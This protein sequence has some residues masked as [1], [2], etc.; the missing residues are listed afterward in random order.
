MSGH[1]TSIDEFLIT[2]YPVMF[3]SFHIGYTDLDDMFM[4]T[5]CRS[6]HYGLYHSLYEWFNPLYLKD[7]KSGFKT[8][9]FVYRKVFPELIDLVKR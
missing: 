1:M 3:N 2:T 6:L 8:Q 5:S 4:N 7:K 9:E